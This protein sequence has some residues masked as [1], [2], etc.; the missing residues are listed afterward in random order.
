MF[1]AREVPVRFVAVRLRAAH[2]AVALALSFLL[3]APLVFP[4]AAQASPQSAQ[5]Q[6]ASPERVLFD[7]ANRERVAKGLKAL[8]WDESLATAAREHAQLLAQRNVLSHQLPGEPPLE[9]RARQAGAR[10]SVIAENVAEGATP[11]ALHSGW[12]HS[13]PHRANLL[14]PELT[15]VGIA[16]AA[17]QERNI[18]GRVLFAVE[19]FSLAVAN[20]TYDQQETQV[21]ALL[22]KRGLQPSDAVDEARKTCEV[23]HGVPGSRA[24]MVVR[25]EAPDLSH[26]PENLEKEIQSGRYHAAAT[27][28]CDPGGAKGSV[29]FR[30]AILLFE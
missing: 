4:R 24:T 22:A 8:Q 10:Y 27:G 30:V 14:A 16:V 12:M 2:L 29:R 3:A 7:A 20:L 15:S 17:S 5:P 26:L 1:S 18:S 28:A 21:A 25:Y 11:E 6:A 9:D 13:A 23:D 19:D